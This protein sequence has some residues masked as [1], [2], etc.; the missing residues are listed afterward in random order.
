MLRWCSSST[1]S[2]E[3]MLLLRF[4]RRRYLWS[5]QPFSYETSPFSDL[6]YV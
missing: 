2:S 1:K 3:E 4:P 6:N 5:Y